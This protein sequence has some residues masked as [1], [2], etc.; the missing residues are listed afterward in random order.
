MTSEEKEVKSVLEQI[1]ALKIKPRTQIKELE[2]IEI[3]TGPLT[4]GELPARKPAGS[5]GIATKL[6]TNYFKIQLKFKKV[7]RYVVTF[8]PDIEQ[9]DIHARR[10][11]VGSF[12]RMRKELLGYN[13]FDGTCLISTN[14]IGDEPR[15]LIHEKS[16]NRLTLK[17]IKA[18]D[19][20][21]KQ[22]LISEEVNM[23][24][25]VFT[26]QLLRAL[27]FLRFRRDYYDPKPLEVK[28]SQGQQR[29][30]SALEQLQQYV[31][32]SAAIGPTQAGFQMSVDTCSRVLQSGTLRQMMDRI[33]E[34]VKAEMTGNVALEQKIAEYRRRVAETFVGKVAISLNTRTLYFIDDFDWSK[35]INDKFVCRNKGE[36]TYK[37]YFNKLASSPFPVKDEKPGLV[38]HTR[39]FKGKLETIL[40]PPEMLQ[41]TGVSDAMRSNFK[42]MQELSQQTRMGP[43]QRVQRISQLIQKVCASKPVKELNESKEFPLQ[44]HGKATEVPAR[45]LSNFKIKLGNTLANLPDNDN[46]NFGTQLAGFHQGMRPPKLEKVAFLFQEDW[47]NAIGELKNMY[48]DQARQFGVTMAPF[49]DVA[50]PK[51]RTLKEAVEN[52]KRVCE[53]VADM[54]PE[55]VIALIPRSEEAIYTMIKSVFNVE[56]GVISQCMLTDTMERC[57][58]R[59]AVVGGSLK[60]LLHKLGCVAWSVDLASS[61][62]SPVLN[63]R[64]MI[65]GMDVSHDKK[66]RSAPGKPLVDRDH[67]TVGFCASYE[68]TFTQYASWVTF[69]KKGDECIAHAKQLMVEA[70]KNFHAKSKGFP[71]NIIVM[72]DGVGNSQI[73]NFV[74][75]EIRLFE[76]AFKELNIKPKLV[77]I[78][79]QKR[80]SARLFAPCDIYNGAQRCGISKRCEGN[81]PWHAP[82]PGTLVDQGIVSPLFSDFFLVPSTA[83]RGA[84]SRPTRFIVAKDDVNWSADDVQTL[85]NHMTYMYLNWAGPIRVPAPCMYAHKAA[86]LFGK[87]IHG[88]PHAKIKDRLFYL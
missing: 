71:E 83:P 41:L 72:R 84:T 82:K 19:T 61:L 45:V 14:F 81:E 44:L 16:G 1:Q 11:E 9:E 39:K 20:D 66:V 42:L 57:K 76:A 25:N 3:P 35:T 29:G 10:K 48:A 26:K 12:S 22:S 27:D 24:A 80:V 21:N 34:E 58:D 50:V 36:V 15:D 87:Y 54:N 62:K 46:R 59:K 56:K 18:I 40:L 30:R 4:M 85:C 53:R 6:S 60:Q 52:W 64:S 8:T 78:I 31:G 75:M 23:I 74:R 28:P 68:R 32:F 73:N 2:G 37:E 67:S 79:V 55:A 5:G 33:Q 7:Y 47:A 51:G 13:A 88:L 17:F 65:I 38:V 43:S 69:Q 86:Y 49:K 77:V 63:T 70:L